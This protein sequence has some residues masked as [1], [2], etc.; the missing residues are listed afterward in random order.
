MLLIRSVKVVTVSEKGTIYDGAL[1]I[2]GETIKDVGPYAQMKECYPSVEELDVGNKIITPS[3]VDCH[4]HLMEYA[5]TMLLPVT[6]ET[7]FLA[8]KNLLFQ[9]L[10]SG[11]TTLGEQ[12]CGHPG[13]HF[14][15]GDFR[16]AA[17]DL[18]MD[19]S[20]ATT[21]ISIGLPEMAHF[22]SVT[23]SRAVQKAEMT[24]GKIVEKI[25]LNSDY[26]GENVFLNATPA[27]FN[28]KEVPRAGELIYSK[29]ELLKIVE[30]FHSLGK[31]IG[32]H[33]AGEEGILLALETGIDV[34]HHA[35][36][37]TEQQMDMVSRK[38]IPIVAT[39]IGGTHL[40]PNSP[41]E[42][43]HLVKKGIRV[44]I[45]TDSY[46]PPHKGATWLPIQRAL[47]G[48]HHLMEVA[49]PAMKLLAANGFDENEILRL[50]TVQPAEIVGNEQVG[51]LAIGKHANFLVA[52][53]VPGLEVTDVE[54]ISM[55]YFKGKR[56]I[57]RKTVR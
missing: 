6:P 5:P 29:A 28:A 46:L 30:T 40:I 32:A 11:I 51:S 21:S 12:I 35:H 17:I 53:G 1:L 33:V 50:L 37:I 44:A 55:V 42:I 26:P 38:G 27:N 34:L 47:Y 10:S 14:S 9:A 22:T 4:T 57:E 7:H 19:V 15:I 13:S 3:L 18:P 52:S 36:G 54:Q 49:Q 56:V 43:L 31:K 20:F 48:P 24:D 25:A 2:H 23:G 39:P 41:H 45:S 8:A 16:K